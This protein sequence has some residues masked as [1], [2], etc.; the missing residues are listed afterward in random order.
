MTEEEKMKSWKKYLVLP[1]MAG[2]MLFGTQPQVTEA[3][4]FVLVK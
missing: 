4:S 2:A 1:L 3:S